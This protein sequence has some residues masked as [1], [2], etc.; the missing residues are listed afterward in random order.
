[1]GV[2]S[3]VLVN[4]VSVP[5]HNI[6]SLIVKSLNGNTFQKHMFL[7]STILSIKR[8]VICFHIPFPPEHSPDFNFEHFN[9]ILIQAKVLCVVL[10][11]HTHIK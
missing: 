11:V 10:Y 7:F 9:H 5:S 3:T 4:L 8:W 1:M 6:K 2:Y